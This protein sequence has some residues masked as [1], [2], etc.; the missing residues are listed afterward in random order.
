M[1]LDS[2]PPQGEKIPGVEELERLEVRL[3]RRLA[4]LE[5]RH[6]KQLERLLAQRQQDSAALDEA[7]MVTKRCERDLEVVAEWQREAE[8]RLCCPGGSAR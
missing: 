7:V 5:L 2:S 8:A 1:P 4:E 3:E 6:Q